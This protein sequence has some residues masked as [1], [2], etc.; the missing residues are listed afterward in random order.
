VGSCAEVAQRS[1]VA[2]RVPGKAQLVEM[3]RLNDGMEES[4]DA[5]RFQKGEDDETIQV[6]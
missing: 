6:S 2:N 3:V 5:T 1:M 4:R